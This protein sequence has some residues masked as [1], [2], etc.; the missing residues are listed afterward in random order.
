MK[1]K[2]EGNVLPFISTFNQALECAINLNA[3]V[4]KYSY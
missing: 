3:Y 1:E 2:K 4:T